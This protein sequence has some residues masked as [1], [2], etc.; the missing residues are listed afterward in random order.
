VPPEP[1]APPARVVLVAARDEEERIGATV[2]AVRRAFPQALVVVADNGSRDETG[3]R[4]RAAGAEVVRSGRRGGKGAAMTAAAETVLADARSGATVIL[5]DGD[6]DVS[7]ERLAPLAGAVESG[8]CDLAVA[9]FALPRGGGFGIAVGF[10][11]WAVRNLTGVD[12]RAPIS[13]Q[14]AL[15]GELLPHLVPFSRGFGIEIGMTADAIRAGARLEE[16][17]LDLEHRATGRTAAGFVHRARQLTAFARVYAA[18]RL[19]PR[20]VGSSAR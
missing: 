11:R 16:V 8:R 4:A 18:R 5:C 14:R 7:A 15:R 9:A 10:A 19:R 3:E 2:G 1:E 6:L 13:G 20:R 17:E 12:A